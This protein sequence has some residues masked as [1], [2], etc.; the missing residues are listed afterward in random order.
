L[1]E[2][3]PEAAIPTKSS[4]PRVG[5]GWFMISSRHRQNESERFMQMCWNL[6]AAS[7]VGQKSIPHNFV[8]FHAKLLYVTLGLTHYE[9]ICATCMS[10]Y[11]G[12]YRL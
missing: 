1:V 8:M 10:V 6:P 12:C 9:T 3:K 11:P 2:I 4:R 5:L 7:C